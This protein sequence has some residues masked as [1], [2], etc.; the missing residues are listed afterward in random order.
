M[1]GE[2]GG[3]GEMRRD[4]GGE[5]NGESGGECVWVCVC[6]RGACTGLCKMCALMGGGDRWVKW[7]GD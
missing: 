2:G 6:V 1:W 4:V 5:K 3:D 7:G